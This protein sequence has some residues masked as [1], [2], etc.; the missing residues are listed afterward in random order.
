MNKSFADS[1]GYT[2]TFKPGNPVTVCVV[3]RD[4]EIVA[5]GYSRCHPGDVYDKLIGVC[6]SF[7]QVTRKYN[8]PACLKDLEDVQAWANRTYDQPIPEDVHDWL[9]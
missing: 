3:T 2:W 7:R 5:I 6:M 1:S 4:G 9:I 8:L